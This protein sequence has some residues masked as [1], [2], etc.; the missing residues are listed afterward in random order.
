M[1]V[2]YGILHLEKKKKYPNETQIQLLLLFSFSQLFD[3]H[4]STYLKNVFLS[5]FSLSLSFLF[6]SYAHFLGLC[7]PQHR[8]ICTWFPIFVVFSFILFFCLM[9]FIYSEVKYTYDKSLTNSKSFSVF[10]SVNPI[11]SS[12]EILY[13]QPEKTMAYIMSK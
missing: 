5:A 8:T 10:F 6:H 3:K 12:Y 9:F 2:V 7:N 4:V 11:C 13:T 1:C